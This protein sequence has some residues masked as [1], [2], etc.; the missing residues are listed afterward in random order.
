[1]SKQYERRIN[2]LVRQYVCDLIER[3]INDPRIAGVTVT[4]VEVSQDVRHATVYYSV[5]GDD[6]KKEEV[7][8]GLRS[9]AGWMSRELAKRLRTRNT[10][11]VHFRFD[12]GL[13]RDDRMSQLLDQIKAEDEKRPKPQQ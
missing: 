2:D 8:Q 6:A 3:E 9:A 10:P 12:Q 7:A 5:I 4:D 13:E 11:H 1:M